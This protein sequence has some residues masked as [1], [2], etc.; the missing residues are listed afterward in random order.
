MYSFADNLEIQ[1]TSVPPETKVTRAIKD[2]AV[3][4]TA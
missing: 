2:T 1:E 4:W 3:A